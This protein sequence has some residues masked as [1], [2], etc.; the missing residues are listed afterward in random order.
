[1]HGL[2][3]MQYSIHCKLA[4]TKGVHCHAACRRHADSLKAADQFPQDVCAV[5][6][7]M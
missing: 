6:L 2:S 1:M 4:Q 3:S 5:G 7:G